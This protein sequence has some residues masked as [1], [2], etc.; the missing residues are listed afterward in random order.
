[1]TLNQVSTDSLA[2]AKGLKLTDRTGETFLNEDH[3]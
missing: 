2:T 1:M 3:C